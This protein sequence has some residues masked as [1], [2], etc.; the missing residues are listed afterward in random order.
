MKLLE[1][2]SDPTLRGLVLPALLAALG[3]AALN[4]LLS[5]AVVLKRLAFIGQGVSHAA[6]GGV[7]LAL[8]LGLFAGGASDAWGTAV[9]AA[10]CVAS[11]LGISWL[12]ERGGGRPDTA[13]GIVLSVAMALG[14]VLHRVAADRAA[15]AGETAPPGLESLLFG[16]VLGVS[17][18]DAILAWA[19]ALAAVVALVH[20]RRR[21]VFWAFEPSAA[22]AFGVSE[23][24]E[25]NA[26]LLLIALAIVV[27]V[28]LAGI[29]LATALLVIPGA[30][31]L[32]LTRRLWWTFALAMVVAL[33]GTCVGLVVS[34]QADLQPGPSI[35][36]A[37]AL[38]Y[39]GAMLIRRAA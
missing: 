24:R 26:L 28:N 11:A 14:F 36:G 9:V 1:Y 19:V 7:G 25:R 10:F 29:V 34:F 18:G 8:V 35:V 31:A 15:A 13:I 38:L 32:L 3:I 17:N 4:A 6:F 27:S 30:T 23:R 39:G 37:L 22:Q 12:S 16:S 21:M 2:L 20:E 5:V 33:I